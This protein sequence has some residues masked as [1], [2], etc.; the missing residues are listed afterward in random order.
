MSS[1]IHWR[2]PLC[3]SKRAELDTVVTDVELELSNK[4]VYW[5]KQVLVDAIETW[6]QSFREVSCGNLSCPEFL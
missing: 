2:G 5:E 3:V 1:A 6:L 4:N